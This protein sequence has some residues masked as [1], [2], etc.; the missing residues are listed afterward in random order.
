MHTNIFRVIFGEYVGIFERIQRYVGR[1]RHYSPIRMRSPFLKVTEQ[2]ESNYSQNETNNE[3]D[4]ENA[5]NQTVIVGRN[6]V[7][8]VTV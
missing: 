7:L 6:I 8:I 1:I 3:T 2:Y 5:T 4:D